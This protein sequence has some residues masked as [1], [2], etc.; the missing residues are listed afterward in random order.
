M[1]GAEPPRPSFG[2]AEAGLLGVLSLVWGAAYVF[3]REGL[4]EGASPLAF[5][6]ARY[7]LTSVAF[8]VLAGLV[9]QP[10]PSRRS[11]LISA[12]IGGA[13]IIGTYGGLL[14]W[15]EQYTT[16]GFAAILAST[17]PLLTVAIGFPLLASERLT[18]WGIAGMGIGLVGATVL[19]A[20]EV[21]GSPLG[22]WQGPLFVVGAM[23][24]TALGT[25][26]LRRLDRGRQSLLQ[27]GTQFAVAAALLTAVGFV[28]PGPNQ[29]PMSTGVLEALALLVVFSSI[30]GYFAYFALH[31]R[32]GP[33][34]ANVVAYLVPLV[35]VGI[36]TGLYGEPTTAWEIVGVA[37]VLVGVSLVLR[38]SGRRPATAAPPDAAGSV[39][40]ASDPS[41]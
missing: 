5:A 29:L 17:A 32:V 35:G 28:V 25:V 21:F 8:V 18:G 14:Y 33:I 23:C 36:G 4:L 19:V 13:L 10:L 6:A 7:A 15:G 11:L 26:L 30:V 27:I 39:T 20:P 41:R 34:R 40:A 38:D 37:V 3:I 22:T 31:H 12:G 16:G 9:R 24:S 2:W 1:S